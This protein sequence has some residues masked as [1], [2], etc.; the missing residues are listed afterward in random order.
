MK[1]IIVIGG[2]V[3]G[4]SAALALQADGHRVTVLEPDRIGQGASWASCGCIAIGEIVPLS[5]PGLLWKVPGLLMDPEAPLA[6]RPA[7]A[8][9]MLPWFLRFV[10]NATDPKMRAIATDL[11]QLTFRATA[12]FKSQMSEYGIKDMLVERPIIKLFEDDSDKA[13][14]GAA[15]NLARDLGCTIEDIPGAEAHDIDP[16]IA[17]DF[18]Y[19]SVLRDWSF[20]ADSVRLVSDLHRAFLARG[21]EVVA[22]D[23]RGFERTDGLLQSVRLQNGDLLEAEEF[24]L[25]AGIGSKALAAEIGVKLPMEGLMGYWT[26]LPEPGV[27]LKHTVFYPSGGFGITP[28]ENALAIAGT[29]EFASLSSKPNWR[30]A[31]VLVERARRVLPRLNTENGERRAGRRPFMPDTRPVIG[32]PRSL[33]NVVIATGHGQLG[34]TLGATTGRVVAD[35]IANRRTDTNL[36]PYGPDRF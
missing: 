32:R 26:G 16:A 11:A 21:G 19:A 24:V 35:I 2:G 7:S 31:D 28:H 27:D 18:Q 10:A 5:Q 14:M 17:P 25:A 9:R 15:F 23:A 30:R 33:G 20:V 13:S 36:T 3:V 12:D 6:L 29:I 22:S 8:L 1:K 4:I 34:L